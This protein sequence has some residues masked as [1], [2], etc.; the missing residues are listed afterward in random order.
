MKINI[1]CINALGTFQGIFEQEELT[2]DE[3]QNVIDTLMKNINKFQHF[4]IR[5]DDGG[6]FV[7]TESI[8][9]NSIFK[10][11]IVE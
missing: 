5:S 3:A 9:K 1:T 4:A 11:M 10:F 8:M 2:R 7:F 6:E